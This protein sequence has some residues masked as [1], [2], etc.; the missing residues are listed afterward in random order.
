M[1]DLLYLIAFKGEYDVELSHLEYLQSGTT[2]QHSGAE[3][4]ANIDL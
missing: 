3:R 1:H 2:R 4:Q